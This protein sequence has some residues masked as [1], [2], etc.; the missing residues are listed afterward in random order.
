MATGSA[1]H[2]RY[3]PLLDEWVLCSPGRLKRPWLGARDRGPTETPPSFD[4]ACYMCPGNRRAG[5]ARNPDYRGVYLFDNDYPALTE[6]APP[7]TAVVRR[8]V[9]QRFQR[10]PVILPMILEA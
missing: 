9:N 5:G 1:S 6:I 2:R 3:N 7:V 4:P 8:F 10:K